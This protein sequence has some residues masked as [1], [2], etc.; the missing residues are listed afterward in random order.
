MGQISPQSEIQLRQVFKSFNRFML[1]LWRLGLGTWFKF[2][3]KVTGQVMVITHT[4]RETGRK[5]R[6]PVNYAVINDEIYCTA[7]FG[8]KADW[9][10]NI[11]A[12][13]DVDVWLPDSWYAGVAEDIS[14][15]PDFL[16]L[17]RQV[18]IGSGFA[19]HLFGVPP[20]LSDERLASLAQNYRL[21]RI[22]IKEPR[23]GIGGPGD[24]AWIWPL[25]T[26]ILLPLALR[27][28]KSRKRS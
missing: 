2:F 7:A 19:A 1:F 13:P 25:A 21:I 10:R 4:G 14:D 28:C 24:L 8:A 3:P 20:S 23:T 12:D 18:L 26:F 27:Q 11:Q 16:F 22:Q 15:S 9:Y 6:T 5:Y 17:I